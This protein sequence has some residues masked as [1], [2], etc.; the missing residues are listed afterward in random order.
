MRNLVL[1]LIAVATTTTTFGQDLSCSGNVCSSSYWIGN[2][3]YTTT[4]TS[5]PGTLYCHTSEPD[6]S[7]DAGAGIRDFMAKG[8]TF[9]EAMK[10]E[11]ARHEAV[12]MESPSELKARH[13]LCD[14]GVLKPDRCDFSRPHP[15]GYRVPPPPPPPQFQEGTP[16]ELA[17]AIKAGNAS[18][19]I[20]N[21][22]P[23]GADIFVDGVQVGRPLEP[24]TIIKKDKPRKIIVKLDGYKPVEKQVMPDGNLIVL[25]FILEKAPDSQVGKAVP[26]KQD[27]GAGKAG[28]SKNK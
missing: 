19:C 25:G 21:I 18:K 23:A 13:E 22:F 16:G 11:E 20:I 1:V 17:E 10:A 24:F 8:M 9:E 7:Y 5:G 26:P 15:N 6:S 2:K 28:S 27:D 3:E 14:E 12:M 4:C